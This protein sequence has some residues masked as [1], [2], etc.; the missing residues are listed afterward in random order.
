MQ[1]SI[2]SIA[3]GVVSGLLT[4]SASVYALGFT[5]A[6]AMPRGFPLALWETAVVFG[7]GTMLVAL[8]IHFLAVRVL[9]ANILLAFMAF[10]ATGVVA[11]R[12]RA[13]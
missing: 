6:L 3:I 2:K 9:A 12:L 10:A 1:Q 5:N 11:L 4:Y 7:L 8:L 13:C